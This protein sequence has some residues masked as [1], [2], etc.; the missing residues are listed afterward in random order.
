MPSWQNLFSL[1][2]LSPVFVSFSVLFSSKA[3]KLSLAFHLSQ[4]PGH[5]PSGFF[6]GAELK[7]ELSPCSPC[8][9]MW[10][11]F[12]ICPQGWFP[13]PPPPFF[14]F[15]LT[16]WLSH[17]VST[18]L[19]L[20]SQFVS[21]SDSLTSSASITFRQIY[22]SFVQVSQ[23]VFVLWLEGRAAVVTPPTA[24]RLTPPTPLSALTVKGRINP[25][26][27]VL[28]GNSVLRISWNTVSIV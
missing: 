18:S 15:L 4:G 27:S 26:S 21:P 1:S 5:K 17:S 9:T 16:N 28:W 11:C 20:S 19:S 14:L 7:L 6:P 12:T 23:T 24:A 10:V 3:A 25:Y 22:F 2:K 8:V 13:V